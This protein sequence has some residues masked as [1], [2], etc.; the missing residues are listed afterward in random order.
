MPA[1]REVVNTDL[2]R[3]QAHRLGTIISSTRMSLKVF[4]TS[5][6][7]LVL[8]ISST[9][10]GVLV[11]IRS[12]SGTEKISMLTCSLSTKDITVD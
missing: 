10:S 11:K 4:H 8:K 9:R 6:L 3:R 7:L 1:F 2:Q 5:D 12:S